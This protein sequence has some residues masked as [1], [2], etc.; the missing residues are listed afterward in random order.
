MQSSMNS[1][2]L[3][4]LNKNNHSGGKLKRIKYSCSMKKTMW[5][6]KEKWGKKQQ[7]LK[8]AWAGAHSAV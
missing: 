6:R 4:T 3:F 2:L 8:L 7:Q 5:N 1:D